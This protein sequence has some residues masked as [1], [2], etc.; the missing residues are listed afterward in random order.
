M[1]LDLHLVSQ[2]DTNFVEGV[3][4]TAKLSKWGRSETMLHKAS[5]R[6]TL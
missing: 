5:R 6:F 4:D 2:V 1:F 3:Y